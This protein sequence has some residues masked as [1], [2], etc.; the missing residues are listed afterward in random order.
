MVWANSVFIYILLAMEDEKDRNA[1]SLEICTIAVATLVM[2]VA[3]T[4]FDTKD[5]NVFLV[6]YG[7]GVLYLFTRSRWFDVKYNSLGEVMLLETSLCFYGGGFFFFVADR[8]QLLSSS[9][10]SVPSRYL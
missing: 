6:C 1:R 9:A 3:I 7:G 2:T 8:S 4:F 10:L 5:Q